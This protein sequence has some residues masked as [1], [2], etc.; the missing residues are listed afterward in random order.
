MK[1]AMFSDTYFPQTNGVVMAIYNFSKE[2][3]RRGHEVHVFA[4]SGGDHEGSRENG[5][6]VHEFPSTTFRR[7]SE[8]E[9]VYPVPIFKATSEFIRTDFDIIHSHTMFTMGMRAYIMSKLFRK[10]LLGSFHTLISEFTKYITKKMEDKVRRLSWLSSRWYYDRRCDAFTVPTDSTKD[11]LRENKFKSR[12]YTLPNGIDPDTEGELR[13]EFVREKHGISEDEKM[14]LYFGRLSI[15]KRVEDL[16]RAMQ[17]LGKDKKLV[18]C[19]KGPYKERLEELAK[20]ID[21]EIIFTGYVSEEL[22]GSYYNAADVFVFPSVGDTQGIVLLEAM[23]YGSP[24]V[25]V[26]AQGIID[27]VKD[28]ENGLLASPQDPEDLAINIEKLAGGAKLQKKFVEKSKEV[29][30]EYSWENAT[31]KLEG[32][33]ERVCGP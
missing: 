31:D 3:S 28:G 29:L 9:I 15:E 7:Y 1:I 2:L 10:P 12:I 25:S 19:G 21:G 13:P 23:K 14:L 4:P 6:K 20:D 17:H 33:Y 24:I 27:L 16:I 30:Y 5:I 32:I 18:I 8:Y 22:K 26:N 11:V